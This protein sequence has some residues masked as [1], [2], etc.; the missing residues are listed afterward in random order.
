MAGKRA[1]VAQ[2]GDECGRLSDSP[3][4]SCAALPA[5]IRNGQNG[6]AAGKDGELQDLEKKAILDALVR[7]GGHQRRAAEILGISRR[8]LGR[9]LKD[10]RME[11]ATV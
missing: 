11:E 2:C 1:G 10:Y 7:V 6:A 5:D 3:E 9:R 8:T 4:I